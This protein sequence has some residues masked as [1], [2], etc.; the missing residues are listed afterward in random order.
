MGI[1]VIFE[2]QEVANR[3]LSTMMKMAAS[4]RVEEP[5]FGELKEKIL[6]L[7]ITEQSQNVEVSDRGPV[8][9]LSEV[10]TCQALCGTETNMGKFKKFNF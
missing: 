5:I 8:V 10:W 6:S 4:F 9:F 2:F 7:L 3:C 1:S